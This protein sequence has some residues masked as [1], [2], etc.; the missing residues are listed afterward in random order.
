MTFSIYSQSVIAR[1][2]ANCIKFDH[3]RVRCLA[4]QRCT[5]T[6]TDKDEGKG[7]CSYQDIK[8]NKPEIVY[9]KD[10]IEVR[11]KCLTMRKEYSAVLNQLIRATVNND[12]LK[13]QEV[14][15]EINLK[16]KGFEEFKECPIPKA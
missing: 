10:E 9:Y 12:S 13:I 1:R 15:V 7:L 8:I 16:L 5:W 3:Q 4:K 6:Y 11:T 2:G 14:K